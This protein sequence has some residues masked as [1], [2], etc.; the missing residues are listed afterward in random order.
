MSDTH[1]IERYAELITRIG[2]NVQRGQTVFV[3]ALVE[4]A[5]L[6]RALARAA[7]A[8]GARLVDV[9]YVDQHVRRSFIE[10]VDDE[11]LSDSPPW[12]LART[13]ALAAG[14]ALIMITGD[15]EPELLADLD[16]ARV[17]KARP[18]EA[19]MRQLRAQTERTLSWTIASYP[20]EGQ[21]LQMFGE[22]DVERLWEAL[23]ATVR[24]DDPDPVAAWHAHTTKLH[25]RCESL[26][27]LDFDAIHFNGPGTD[28]TVGLLSDAP[29]MG[30]GISTVDGIYHVPNLPTEEVFTSPDW[31]RTEGTV[32]STRPLHLGGTIVRDLALRF[33]GGE[34]VDVRAS[35]GADAVRGEL[36][37]DEFAKRLG[38]V[39][40]V[41]GESRV[42][43][44][45]LVFYDTLFDENATCH[46]A[47]GLGGF[48]IDGIDALNP[49]EAR[50]R[51]IN[52]SVVH[53]DFMIGGPEV[54][55]D[56]I[57]K[58]GRRV[59]ILREDVWQLR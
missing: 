46:I 50:A 8:A 52:I 13:E 27:S 14:G 48:G 38:E 12:V 36:A 51:G 53:T 35:A 24:L 1:R 26:D 9:R 43:Q 29:W 10:S 56:G 47:Y 5:P 11:T 7:Y 57:T 30:G 6:V 23:A 3:S 41:D 40:L 2:V 33:S 37:L 25:E 4:H 20:T 21:A 54:D 45:G 19:T 55:V 39:A 58:D 16:Q 17:S 59:P 34:I 31:R 49:D 44:T 22:P 18:L 15:P 28:L 32:R 42:G